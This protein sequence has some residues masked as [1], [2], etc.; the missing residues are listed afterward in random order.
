MSNAPVIYLSTDA[1]ESETDL[2]QSLIVLNGQTV[3]LVKRPAHDG[4]GKWDAL[5][6]RRHLH[7]DDQ[8][9][10]LIFLIFDLLQS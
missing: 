4:K 3:P 5:L 6:Y 2:L 7:S 10:I 1:P 8:V 9:Y